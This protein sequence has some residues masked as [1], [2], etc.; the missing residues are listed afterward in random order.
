MRDSGQC[1]AITEAQFRQMHLDYKGTA[2]G[3]TQPA[4]KAVQNAARGST[5][6]PAGIHKHGGATSDDIDFELLMDSDNEPVPAGPVSAVP[7]H[8]RTD[9]A[10][11]D[12]THQ[13]GKTIRVCRMSNP[14]KIRHDCNPVKK[15]VRQ[16]GS[17]ERVPEGH[18]LIEGFKKFLL[19][20]RTCNSS[21]SVSQYLRHCPVIALQY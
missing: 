21:A 19:K 13:T 18:E 3:N 14:D 15:L 1:I 20:E 17:Y 2:Q 8:R 12:P 11:Y 6:S 5:T 9:V 4:A 10:V 16:S 7:T